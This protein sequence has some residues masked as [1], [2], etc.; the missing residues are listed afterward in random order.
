[1]HSILEGVIGSRDSGSIYR[2]LF[3][4]D[5][6]VTLSMIATLFPLLPLLLLSSPLYLFLL[7]SHQW[8]LLRTCT[9]FHYIQNDL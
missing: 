7:L 3:I 5:L 8:H 4:Y 2:L 6:I 1:M 9:T